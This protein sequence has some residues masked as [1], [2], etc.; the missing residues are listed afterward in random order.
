MPT[1]AV[2]FAVTIGL[3]FVALLVSNITLRKLDGRITNLG[4]NSTTKTQLIRSAN[5]YSDSTQ[6]LAILVPPVVGLA[7]GTASGSGWLQFIYVAVI[8]IIFVT[9]LVFGM[10]DPLDYGSRLNPNIP[11]TW[12]GLIGLAVNIVALI[13]VWIGLVPVHP[14][15]AHPV[16]AHSVP[17]HS[18]AF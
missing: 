2:P 8:A 4:I 5:W 15:P 6:A 9:L 7:V 16:P 12:L 10:R 13:I 1:G 14:V 18:A 11:I 17:V 3:T